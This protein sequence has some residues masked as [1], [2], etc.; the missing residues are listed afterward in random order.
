M[1]FYLRTGKRL[2]RRLTEIVVQ[3]QP[4]RRCCSA[5]RGHDAG[6]SERLVLHIQPDEGIALRFKAKRPGPPLR[7]ETVKMDFSYKDFGDT[8]RPPATRGCS[9]TA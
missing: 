2:A 1:P 5:R 8:S 6:R 4:R 3:F 7:I 9:T